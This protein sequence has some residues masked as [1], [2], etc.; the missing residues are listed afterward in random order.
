MGLLFN[1]QTLNS[2]IASFTNF[3]VSPENF[4]RELVPLL[5]N[6]DIDIVQDFP[7]TLSPNTIVRHNTP[8]IHLKEHLQLQNQLNQSLTPYDSGVLS[9]GSI[10]E[11]VDANT[12]T[13]DFVTVLDG[14]HKLGT[15]AS[16][17][18]SFIF[19]IKLEADTTKSYA[20][21]FDLDYP[22]GFQYKLPFFTDNYF[23]FSNTWKKTDVLDSITEY[24]RERISAV[25]SLIFATKSDEEKKNSRYQSKANITQYIKDINSYALKFLGPAVG[26]MDMPSIWESTAPREYTFQFPLYN[27]LNY[28]D[29][30]KSKQIIQKNW[31]LCYLLTYQNL[32][33]KKNFYNGIP[34]VFYEVLIPGIHYCKA[35]YIS[36]LDITNI[37]N[38][39]LMQVPVGDNNTISTIEA[40]VPDA[41]MVS[42]TL[43]DLLMPSKNLLNKALDPVVISSITK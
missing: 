33:N 41:Y 14:I 34:P 4:A 40:I 35:S 11:G 42:I 31:E 23:D 29:S 12:N 24:Q 2:K 15:L 6:T 20:G 22:T 17:T 27:N 25:E 26:L 8:F 19:G 5:P 32:V 28:S 18:F 38:T 9:A 10:N 39:R 7:W 30:K 36:K 43:K 1:K 13:S 21:I 16:N 37:G 3:A